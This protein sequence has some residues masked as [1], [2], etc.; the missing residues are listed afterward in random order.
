MRALRIDAAPV[1]LSL[2]DPD[3]EDPVAR[4]WE[5]PEA[6]RVRVLTLL[7]ALI[8]RGVLVVDEDTVRGAGDPGG[9]G[10]ANDG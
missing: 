1:Q 7:A 9:S 10:Q 3:L 6:T 5:L 8:A 2:P 4:W